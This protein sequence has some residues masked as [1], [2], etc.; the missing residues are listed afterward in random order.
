MDVLRKLRVNAGHITRSSSRSHRREAILRPAALRDFLPSRWLLCLRQL[1]VQF[2]G[3]HRVAIMIPAF[4]RVTKQRLPSFPFSKPIGFHPDRTR[5]P[6][7][8]VTRYQGTR[9]AFA[10]RPLREQ[11][12][13]QTQTE[14]DQI[15]HDLAC[16]RSRL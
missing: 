6:P 8:A 15:D 1:L 10:D 7:F 9:A 5:K 14:C 12:R 4:C 11:F 13:D 2:T 3:T 16:L